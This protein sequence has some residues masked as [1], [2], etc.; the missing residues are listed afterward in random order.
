MKAFLPAGIWTVFI[1]YV[2]VVSSKKLPK[3]SL[4]LL[5]PDKLAHAVVYCI[6]SISLFYGL[7]QINKGLSRQQIIG[8]M[9]FS[10][11]YGIAMEFVQYFFFPG[12][13][14]EFYDMLANI[15][16]VICSLFLLKLFYLQKA[17]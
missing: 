10:S 4:T 2:S 3:I 14:L 17:S 7:Y 15:I 11:L 6:L 5:E 13:F 8:A 1:F 9:V 12:R 16:G